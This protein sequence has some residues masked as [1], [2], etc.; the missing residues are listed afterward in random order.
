M[1]QH[2]NVIEFCAIED[3]TQISYCFDFESI[4]LSPIER[5]ELMI[6]FLE[7]YVN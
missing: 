3:D 1:N 5:K 2:C 6:D 7:Q 4:V